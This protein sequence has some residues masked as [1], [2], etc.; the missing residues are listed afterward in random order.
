MGGAGSAFL[1]FAA[2]HPPRPLL[3]LHHGGHG[4]MDSAKG[5]VWGETPSP[6]RGTAN[7]DGGQHPFF[8]RFPAPS[9]QVLPQTE[10]GGTLSTTIVAPAGAPNG[11]MC[12]TVTLPSPIAPGATGGV[13]AFGSHARAQEPNPATISRGDPQR[14]KLAY[15]HVIVSPYVVKE[16]TTK[17]RENWGVVC[18]GRVGRREGRV[19]TRRLLLPFTHALPSLFPSLPS[20]LPARPQH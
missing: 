14:V 7:P 13:D 3:D 18:A 6:P 15:S 8:G 16:Q 1:C 19:R 11:T 4:V 17:V 5:R 2:L 20:A 10:A 12:V 9:Q